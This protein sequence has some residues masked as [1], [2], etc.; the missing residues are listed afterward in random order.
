L[1]LIGD[2]NEF[3]IEYHISDTRNMMGYGKVWI[4][5]KFY[6][7]NQDLIYLEGY[8]GNLI[9]NIL[10]AQ[11]V[12]FPIEQ[13]SSESI[14]EQMLKLLDE[15]SD[16]LII[17]STFTDD[18]MGFKYRDENHIVLVWKLRD[19]VEMI[20]DDLKNYSKSVVLVRVNSE[21]VE[22]VMNKFENEIK[23]ARA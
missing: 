20:F 16:Y 4:Q 6:G 10:N 8:L 13:F 5:N 14:Y 7:T 12:H 2:K 1:K 18:F 23:K 21:I 9:K 11:Q 17:S 3:A 19:D 22:E 15:T